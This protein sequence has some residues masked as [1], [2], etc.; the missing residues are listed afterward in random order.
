MSKRRRPVWVIT[1]LGLCGAALLFV[2]LRRGARGSPGC[3]QDRRF[4][5]AQPRPAGPRRLHR[6]APRGRPPPCARGSGE[7]AAGSSP[8]RS[9]STAGRWAPTH[10]RPTGWKRVHTSS[11]PKGRHRVGVGAVDSLGARTAGQAVRVR[12]AGGGRPRTVTPATGLGPVLDALAE[13]GVRVRLAPGRYAVS[14]LELGDGARLSGSG[15]RTVLTAAAPGLL[16]GHRARQRRPALPDDRRSGPRRPRGGHRGRLARRAP[17][18]AHDRRRADHRRRR[19]GRAPRISVQDS[20]I[21]GAGAPAPACSCA[22]RTAR[23]TRASSAPASAASSATGSTSPS[24]QR[25]PERGEQ[26]VALDNDITAIDDPMRLTGRTRGH[27][28][29]RRAGGHH[30]QPD[31]RTGWNGIETVGSSRA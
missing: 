24:V 9:C 28:V 6:A 20:V 19:V 26:R 31:A 3:R 15:S 29:R 1:A 13:G 11:L 14:Q 2:G 7:G 27:L 17:P 8:S 22:A 23:G 30:R 25:P 21:D 18:A 10:G 16:A 12:I 5:R 4:R